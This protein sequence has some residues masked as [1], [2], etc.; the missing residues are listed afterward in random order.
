MT[1]RSMF[2]TLAFL[3]SAV[4]AYAEDWPCWRGPRYDGTSVETGIPV[5]WSATDNIAWKTPLPGKGHS[6]PAIWGDRIFLTSCLENENKQLILCL[7]RKDG[8]ILWQQ[9]QPQKIQKAIHKLNSHAS[10]TAAT[11][12]KY[13]Y[14]TF[15]DD[16]HF[17]VCCYDFDGKLMWKK[18]PGDFYSVHGF[19]SSPLLYKDL[20]ILNGDQ[21]SPKGSYYRGPKEN[22]DK[23]KAYDSYLVAL[24]KATGAE[25][26][27]TNRP[28]NIRSY[29]P[30]VLFD[31]AGKKQIVFSG[32]FSVVSYDPDT[33]KQNW[34]V[35]NG[36]TE[37]FVSSMVYGDDV[38]FMT[39]GFPKRGYAGFKPDGTGDVSKTH[40]LFNIERDGGY[41]PSPIYHDKLFFFV[42]D[43]GLASCVDS[44]TGKNQWKERIGKHCSAS[45]I[46]AEGRLYFID[47]FGVT[48]VLKAGAKYEVVQ[49]NEIGEE[50]YSSPAI[51]RGQLY[52]RG[53]HTLFCIGTK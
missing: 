16:P 1:L 44:K 7:D 29:T 39:Y 32:C 33:G 27:R 8:K 35:D 37:Q 14:V 24:D 38:L 36:P 28:H 25:R 6:S 15:H 52:I 5:K 12:G 18:S 45:P 23:D 10:S 17:V 2:L 41:V 9:D 22:K 3:V 19:C 13:V 47:D 48:T 31:M 51:S 4:P 53:L 49:K 34:I 40:V 26:W 11:D 20:V 46:S 42:N 43:E 50:V 30:P 21:D